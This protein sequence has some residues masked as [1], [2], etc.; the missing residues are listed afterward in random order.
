MSNIFRLW[1]RFSSSLTHKMKACWAS[2]FWMASKFQYL[3][4]P[5]LSHSVPSLSK[6]DS[7]LV[8]FWY[9]LLYFCSVFARAK[10]ILWLV[11]RSPII[12]ASF[13]IIESCYP[14]IETH[15]I[16][17]SA[18]SYAWSYYTAWG[19]SSISTWCHSIS[20]SIH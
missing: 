19:Q 10:S 20:Q 15:A 8:P 16:I 4:T 9:F 17:W 12:E 13:S 11:F 7:I 18:L 2:W 5:Q 1:S 14:I 3:T 6:N